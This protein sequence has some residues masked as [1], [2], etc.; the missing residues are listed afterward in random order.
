M[1]R[2]VQAEEADMSRT[3]TQLI[4]EGEYAAEVSIELIEDETGW[5][6]H[7]SEADVLK[8]DRVR[9]ALRRGGHARCKGLRADATIGVTRRA[10]E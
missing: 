9:R 6:P 4:H 3:T 1:G 7:V 8:L 2:R 10:A 5:S